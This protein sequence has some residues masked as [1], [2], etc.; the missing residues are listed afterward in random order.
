MPACP[1]GRL[2]AAVSLLAISPDAFGGSIG[3]NFFSD[4]ARQ[5]EL[6]ADEPAGVVPQQNWNN[7][8]AV[9]ADDG[10]Y[11]WGTAEIASPNAGVIT[12]DDEGVAAVLP[13]VTV[14]WT[15]LHSWDVPGNGSADG[16]DKLM[17]GYLDNDAGTPRIT[18]S[19]EDLP[20]TYTLPG[21]SVIAYL[22]S[23]ENGRSG[24]VG[25]TGGEGDNSATITWSARA[26]RDYAVEASND[27]VEWEELDDSVTAESD[28]GTYT[29][30]GIAAGTRIRYYR[31]RRS[32]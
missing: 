4:R 28:T 6:A 13:E 23:D 9:P 30:E 2:V 27:L 7:F 25:I 17:N 14:S 20:A 32:P 15:A 10:P 8:T 31:V 29:E 19:V 21:Y 16:D 24:T 11:T 18:V 5:A 26:G 22:G 12:E 3:F 1:V